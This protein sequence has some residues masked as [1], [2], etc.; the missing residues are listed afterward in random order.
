MPFKF[1][2]TQAAEDREVESELGSGLGEITVQCIN[3]LVNKAW[4]QSADS[5]QQE[6]S[7][8]SDLSKNTILKAKNVLDHPMRVG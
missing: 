5:L 2:E 4:V 7:T 1:L 3:V 8:I 6:K